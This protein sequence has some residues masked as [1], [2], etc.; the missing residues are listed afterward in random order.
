MT[1]KIE[2]HYEFMENIDGETLPSSFMVN[3]SKAIRR[4]FVPA[5]APLD[6]LFES[7]TILISQYK[8]VGYLL[9]SS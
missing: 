5:K 6:R 8:A 1:N 2:Q 7:E 4:L 9:L 3:K